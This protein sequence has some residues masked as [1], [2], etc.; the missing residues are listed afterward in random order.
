MLSKFQCAYFEPSFS[1]PLG[2]GKPDRRPPCV[3]GGLF[4]Y[5]AAD[6]PNRSSKTALAGARAALVNPVDFDTF[7]AK[8]APKERLN[9]ERHIAACEAEEDPGHAAPGAAS[10][11]R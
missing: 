10:P 11:A 9:A 3:L 5:N 4:G 6:M 7:L 1:P 2:P 8:L